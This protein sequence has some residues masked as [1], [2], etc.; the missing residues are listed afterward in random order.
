[1]LK[2]GQ[3]QVWL[4]KGL[5]SRILQALQGEQA[6]KHSYVAVSKTASQSNA[7]QQDN[8]RVHTVL[9][10]LQALRH[11]PTHSLALEM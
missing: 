10:P 1:M 2:C 11:L 3:A 4:G 7:R 5:I 9:S 8:P 6:D